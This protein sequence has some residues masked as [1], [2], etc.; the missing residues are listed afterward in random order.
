[1]IDYE[2]ARTWSLCYFAILIVDV[3]LVLVYAKFDLEPKLVFYIDSI[4]MVLMVE[5]FQTCT[6]LCLTIEEVPVEKCRPEITQF[7]SRP[8]GPFSPRRHYFPPKRIQSPPLAALL[9]PAGRFAHPGFRTVQIRRR[10]D[11]QDVGNC[12]QKQSFSLEVFSIESD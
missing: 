8:P 3:F 4:V 10:T 7:Y 11:L 2:K 12:S 6:T 9:P 5:V 1:M